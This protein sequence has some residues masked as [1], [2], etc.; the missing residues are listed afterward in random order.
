VLQAKGPTITEACREVA[1]SEQTYCR[2]QKEYGR[3]SPDQARGLKELERKN[4][5]LRKLVADLSLDNAI[6][7]EVTS[8]N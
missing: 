2:W 7:R 4:V 6:L 5:R 8:G 3:L 1:V